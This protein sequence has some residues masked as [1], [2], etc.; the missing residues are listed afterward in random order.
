MLSGGGLMGMNKII[1]EKWRPAILSYES[2][3]SYQNPFLDVS[4][5]AEFVGPSG[6]RIYREAY[7]DGENNYKISFAP[8]EVGEWKWELSAPDKTG[9]KGTKGSLVCVEYTGNLDIYKHGFLKVHPCG[10]YLTYDDGTPFFW[11]GDTHWGFAFNEK[12]DESNHPNM[13]SMFRGMADKRAEQGFNVYQTNLRSEGGFHGE[14][15]RYWAGEEPGLLPNVEFYQN[16]LDRRMKYLADQG[17]VNALGFAWSGSVIG[18]LQLQKNLARYIV[19]RYGAY[20]MVWALAGEVAGYF[21]GENR[22][23]C[24]DG[25]REVAKY[26][27]SIDGYG[28]LQTAHYTN[29]R[30][31]ANYYQDEDWFDFT[32]NQAGHGDFPISAKHYR[33]HRKLYPSKPFIESEALYEFVSTLEELGSR[34]CTA[35]MLRRVAYM[36]IQLGGCGYT[37]G[38][39]GIWDHVWEKPEKPNPF[40]I[41]NKHGITWYEAI[42]GEGAVQMGYMRKFYE[43]ECFWE[44]R[45]IENIKTDIAFSDEN[46]F[47]MFAPMVTGN[48]DMSR[49]I[50]YYGAATRGRCT[51]T[52]LK[53]TEYTAKWFDPR[54]GKY[55]EVD[56]MITPED[57]SWKAFERPTS[58]DWLL[59]LKVN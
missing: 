38:A 54:S 24:I 47:G 12:W 4:I 45:P 9:L 6:K 25:W 52:G 55:I 10:R 41:F 16:E 42:E 11:L 56:Q 33:E 29:E 48:D 7:W 2:N 40:N 59:V 18:K 3:H 43:N 5:S 31:F 53:N 28:T 17:F 13:D 49:I 50:I 20:P 1:V 35:D 27:E 23:Q 21:G 44:L 36:S 22:Q 26:V 19:A 34:I 46:L 14:K 37:Y 58:D 8:T 32:L 51:L 39:Q 15:S 57:G 30:P